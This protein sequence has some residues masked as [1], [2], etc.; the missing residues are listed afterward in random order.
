MTKNLEPLCTWTWRLAL[1]A[2]TLKILVYVLSPFLAGAFF[3]ALGGRGPLGGMN[4]LF[5]APFVLECLWLIVQL[6]A[7]RLIIEGVRRVSLLSDRP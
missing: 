3:T 4:A 6:M 1:I 7:L 5:L 2:A